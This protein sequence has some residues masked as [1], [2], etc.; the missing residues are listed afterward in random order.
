VLARMLLNLVLD[1][2]LGAIPLVGDLFDLAWRGNL[3]NVALLDG[4]LERPHEIRRRS[5]A[6][7]LLLFGA[8]TG[9]CLLSIWFALWLLRQLFLGGT[10]GQVG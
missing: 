7:L 6:L 2:T 4:W 8:L 3:R 9:L 5:A 10:S 1:L